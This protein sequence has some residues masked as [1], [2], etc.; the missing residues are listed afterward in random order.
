MKK[1]RK[2]V[3][4]G[5]SCAMALSLA[6]CGDDD[7]PKG[8]NIKSNEVTQAQWA[9][10]FDF[11]QVTNM[12]AKMTERMTVDGVSKD[13]FNIIK[14]DGSNIYT[15]NQWYDGD[16]VDKTVEKAYYS[17]S[18]SG[19]YVYEYDNVAKKWSKE[20]TEY[21]PEISIVVASIAPLADAY[22]S[23]TYNAAK[24]GYV[25]T[26]IPN[27]TS[28]DFD[29]F[30]IKIIDGKINTVQM[31]MTISEDGEPTSTASMILQF[32]DYGTTSV[33]LPAVSEEAA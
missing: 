21:Y 30:I 7:G 14:F 18:E 16:A 10:A 6:A 5:L 31:D 17:M 26:E 15:E 12:T 1:Y 27:F 28:E 8:N 2:I 22:T 20:A 23:F 25:A 9:S 33:T 3:A 19:A 32:Y 4:I 29:V 24:G 13:E 11:S